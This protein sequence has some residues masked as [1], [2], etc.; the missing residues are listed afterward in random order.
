M[1]NPLEQNPLEKEAYGETAA[2]THQKRAP[3]L[4]ST[5]GLGDTYS[6]QEHEDAILKEME[7]F[8]LEIG[9]GFAF[10]ARQKKFPSPASGGR[11][12]EL[13]LLFYH[14][15]LKRLVAIE[16]KVGPFEPE[17]APTRKGRV[18]GKWNPICAG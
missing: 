1:Q 3:Y 6:E 14:R 2:A 15:K 10:V 13:D 4:L 17:R 16:L 18:M 11:V 7:A 12:R 5:R 8:V 9:D